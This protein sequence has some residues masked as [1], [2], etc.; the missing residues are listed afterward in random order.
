MKTTKF[1]SENVNANQEERIKTRRRRFNTYKGHQL[2]LTSAFGIITT[3]SGHFVGLCLN[4]ECFYT[5]PRYAIEIIKQL[6]DVIEAL[7][8]KH[9]QYNPDNPRATDGGKE[10]GR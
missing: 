2:V 3:D 8:G 10:E 5:Q 6:A 1:E 9:N 7:A 4:E